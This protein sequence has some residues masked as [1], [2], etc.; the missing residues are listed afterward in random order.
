[1]AGD[2]LVGEAVGAPQSDGPAGAAAAARLAAASHLR[3]WLAISQ[4]SWVAVAAAGAVAA[5]RAGAQVG[6]AAPVGAPV[7]VTVLPVGAVAMDGPPGTA[8]AIPLVTALP[9]LVMAL[10]ML[11]MVLAMRIGA[12]ASA[13]RGPAATALVRASA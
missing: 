10:P 8:A 1:M 4:S 3:P 6:A 2:D 11:V 5:A 7:G 12:A 13:W 9:M